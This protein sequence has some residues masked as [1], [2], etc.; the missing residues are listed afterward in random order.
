M[1]S[2]SKLI[3]TFLSG[4]SAITGISVLMNACSEDEDNKPVVE[5]TQEQVQQC[6]GTDQ[7][8]PEYPY[9]VNRYIDSG[10]CISSFKI[11]NCCGSR[12]D[13]D[14]YAACVRDYIQSGLCS[15]REDPPAPVYGMIE[16]PPDPDIPDKEE[17][18]DCCGRD[19]GTAL[20]KDCVEQFYSPNGIEFCIRLPIPDYIGDEIALYGPPPDNCCGYHYPDDED[21]DIMSIP[22]FNVFLNTGICP[23]DIGYGKI[24]SCCGTIRDEEKL[25]ACVKDYLKSGACPIPADAEPVYGMP[26]VP[27]E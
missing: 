27:D 2:F 11:Q 4:I 13:N 10:K 24:E 6:C 26:D 15:Q 9:C 3:G 5:V 21:F 1:K 18:F 23:A 16:P 19:T 25:T 8:D 17:I 20:Y 7:T 14:N 12:D 22:C